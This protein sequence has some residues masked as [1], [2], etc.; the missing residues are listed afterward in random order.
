MKTLPKDCVCV[1]VNRGELLVSPGLAVYCAVYADEMEA[2]HAH[3]TDPSVSLPE[4][5]QTRLEKHGFYGAQRPLRPAYHLTQF[6]VTNACN[7]HCA[8]CS[9]DSGKAREHEITLA[10]VCR[11][12]DGVLEIYPDSDI[13][14]SGGEPLIV[15]WLFE[16]VAY[17]LEHTK[18]HVGILS[19]LLL[20]DRSE[21]LLEKLVSVMKRGVS[22][23]MSFAAADRAVC[24]RLSGAERYD[25]GMRV[26][27]KLEARGVYPKIDLML[28]APDAQAN[29]D[30]FADFRRSLAEDAKISLGFLYPCG[31]ETGE[32][33]FRDEDECERILD[34]LTFLGGVSIPAPSVSSLTNRR[35]GC[36]CIEHENLY[37]RSDGGVFSCFKMVEQFGDISE[38]IKNVIARRRKTPHKA[39]ELAMCRACPFVS[40]CAGGC[41]ADNMILERSVRAPICGA[42]RVR[43]LA[44]ML[45]EDRP[46]VMDWSVPHQLEEAKKRGLETPSFVIV[47]AR[48]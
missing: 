46:Y 1:P 18:G 20:L 38:G 31:R 35:L 19:N 47:G 5:L 22:V 15:P 30:A 11:V 39:A 8:Y 6:Q 13:S 23:Q 26:L 41:R 25:I 16:A 42:W 2:L 3:L 14:F 45:F 34:D 21:V 9:A 32:H 24:D 43:L 33:V 12:I 10:D 36:T 28:S 44:E 4:A 29:V 37:I 27:S 40:L 17:A 7:L 48:L